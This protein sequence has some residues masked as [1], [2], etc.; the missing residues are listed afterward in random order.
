MSR[1]YR[2]PTTGNEIPIAGM[3]TRAEIIEV[4]ESSD[5]DTANN[6]ASFTSSDASTATAWTSVGVLASGETHASIFAKVSQMFKNIRY[7][8]DCV[9]KG[10]WVGTLSGSC[11]QSGGA[12]RKGNA[13]TV[14]LVLK[15]SGLSTNTYY[16]ISTNM[17]KAIMGMS[18]SVPNEYGADGSCTV[19][20]D[21]AGKL[22]AKCTH[23]N[24]YYYACFTYYTN[25]SW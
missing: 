25:D 15:F 2:D 12:Y 5:V 3:P 4:A 6:T 10:N 22:Q 1:Y 13:V 9:V 7:L 16:T 23:A 8:Y 17:P 21:G 24:T 14:S 11:F 18:I 20:I 19:G